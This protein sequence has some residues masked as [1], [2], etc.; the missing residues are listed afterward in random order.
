MYS[1]FVD[2]VCIYDDTTVLKE[3]KL[4]NPRFIQQDNMAGSLSFIMAQTNPGYSLIEPFKNEVQIKK[5]GNV[6]WTGRPITESKNFYNQKSITCEGCYG[7]LN[8]TIQPQHNYHSTSVR[9]FLTGLINNHNSQSTR[10]FSVRNVTDDGSSHNFTTDYNNTLECINRELIEDIGG[11][12]SVEKIGDIYYIDYI[13]N[14]TYTSSQIIRF[15]KNLLDFTQDLDRTSIA[16][17]VIPFGAVIEYDEESGF[18][19]RVDI[20]SV[21]GG[22]NYLESTEAISEYGRIVKVE[23]WDYVEDPAQLKN[24]GQRYLQ[25]VQFEPVRLSI[26]AVDLT[27]FGVDTEEFKMLDLVRVISDPHGL[28]KYFPIT[29]IDM[30]LND[31]G[32]TTYTMGAYSDTTLSS[33]NKTV[34][35][36]IYDVTK[37]YSNKI[38]SAYIMAS[39]ASDKADRAIV[40]DVLHYLATPLSSGVTTQTPGWTT[41][42]QS[43]TTTNKYL[44]TYHTYT[45]ADEHISNTSPVITGVYGEDG[46]PG[47]QGPKGDKGDTGDQG[48][49]GPKGDKGD[50]GDQGAQ[51]P[52]GDNGTSVTVSS[53]QYASSTSGTTAPTSGWQNTIPTVA[54]G[55][56]LWTK[57]TYSNGSIAYTNS[58]QGVNGT[59]GTSVTITSQSV[60]YQVG[61][62][63]T[64]A[65]TGTWKST[66]Q[67]TSTGQFLWTRTI[68]NY[69]NG[70]ST[71]SYSVSAHGSTGS[72]GATGVGIKEVTSIYYASNS[73]TAPSAPSSEVTTTSTNVYNTWTKGV[74]ALTSTYNKLYTCDQVKYTNNTFAWTTP[75]LDSAITT[76]VS[77]I[78]QLADEIVLKVKSDGTVAQV[79]L[80][81]D[82]ST[83][84]NVLIKGD[85]IQLDGNVTITNGFV[86]NAGV[87][88]SSNYDSGVSGTRIDLT[89]GVIDAVDVSIKGSITAYE[90]I[91]LYTTYS[92]STWDFAKF[93][94]ESG[95]TWEF[96]INAPKYGGS[97][98][99]DCLIAYT[100]Q[101]DDPIFYGKAMKAGRSDYLQ[102]VQTNSIAYNNTYLLRSRYNKWSD[103]RFGLEI[104]NNTSGDTGTHGVRVDYATSAGS[105][106]TLAGQ[107]ANLTYSTPAQWGNWSGNGFRTAWYDTANKIS[108][109][110]SQYGFLL[111]VGRS[112]GEGHQIWA[113]Q[114]NGDLYH[115]G[116]NAGSNLSSL[117]FK[118]I[119]DSSNG[120][121]SYADNTFYRVTAL[122]TFK[123]SNNALVAGDK[124]NYIW[125]ISSWSDSRLKD[126]VK[127]SRV[128]ALN[129]INNIKMREFDF[130]DEKYGHHEDIGYVAQELKEV[131]PE[132]VVDVPILEE[133]QKEYKTDTLMQVEDKHLIKYLVKAMQE[134]SNEVERLKN[135]VQN[136]I[137]K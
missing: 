105:A 125:G 77:E 11:H 75:V 2:G 104:I 136:L 134:L 26:N 121:Q 112:Y 17:V 120:V 85:N 62:S 93:E 1:I 58:R 48:A 7:Y 88:Q 98:G 66:P 50:T 65:P 124:G 100:A 76:A 14:L 131:V 78:N 32:R 67:A 28:N 22:K 3:L 15:G 97:G 132:C 19:R 51:G 95:D 47:A 118:K 20:T 90:G 46:S 37:E 109:Q 137:A 45:Y 110:P 42:P 83:G 21:N 126:N 24:I 27:N 30:P 16:T 36:Y 64:T 117:T 29:K 108:N 49:Q 123:G 60:T 63:G 43:M 103:G 122:I 59:N 79:K 56:Y 71:T 94:W 39:D 99:N 72:P 33:N 41:T 111:H 38:S 135:M 106:T 101:F 69:S 70:T 73:S 80:G 53:V 116:F 13:Y 55:S 54:Q 92:R 91:K 6:I 102:S 31:L 9:A 115:R 68:V 89:T 25:A 44:W 82:A 107:D 133:E 34:Q 5:N 86:L 74:P 57:T 10:Q 113:T 130:I 18:E 84:S 8:D 119:L 96:T 40:T 87:I 4:I 61:S 81:T 52:K 127:D 23:T 35:N 12:I 114:A 129:I 128:N